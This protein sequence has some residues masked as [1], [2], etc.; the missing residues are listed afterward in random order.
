[1]SIYCEIC[2]FGQGDSPLG[3]EPDRREIE[4]LDRPIADD[5]TLCA[6]RRLREE[7]Y[8]QLTG[9]VTENVLIAQADRYLRRSEAPVSALVGF[10]DGNRVKDAND[11]YG[12][13]AGDRGIFGIG[14]VIANHLRVAESYVARRVRGSDEFIFTVFGLD[15]EAAQSVTRRLGSELAQIEVSVDELTIIVGATMAAKYLEQ[16]LSI[17]DIKDAIHVTDM[18][19]NELKKADREARRKM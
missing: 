6:F 16:V 17:Q 15:N 5:V 9:L 7:R 10:A 12:H 11:A 3:C 14:A 18:A 8:D 4:G 13:H 2:P 1:M 19:V